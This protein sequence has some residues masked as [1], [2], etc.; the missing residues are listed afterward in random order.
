MEIVLKYKDDER[1]DAIKAMR[2]SSFSCLVWELQKYRRELYKGYNNNEIVVNGNRV[3]DDETISKQA[4]QSY[5]KELCPEEVDETLPP[6]KDNKAYI[7]KEDVLNR[8][9]EILDIVRDVIDE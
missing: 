9:D 8:I 2:V 4:R 5:A 6:F 3:L 1:E 7:W